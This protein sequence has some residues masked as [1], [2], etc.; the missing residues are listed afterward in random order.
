MT[1]PI[2]ILG[3]DPGLRRTGWGVVEIDGNRLAFVGCGSVTSNDRDGLGDAAAR[4]PRRADA[5][6]RRIPARR[7]RGRGDFRQ[8]GRPGDAQTRPGAR[9]RHG[10][11]GQGRHAGRRI[12]AERGEEEHRRRRP[13]RQGPDAHDDR[14]A[15]AQGRS[16]LA[17]RRRCARHRGDARASPAECGAQG[18]GGAEG[19]GANRLLPD[20]RQAQR[21]HRLLRRGLRHPRRRRRRLSGALLGAHLAGI[22]ARRRS[23]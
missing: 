13:R 10:G 9:H 21:H 11:A 1:R 8:Q 16:G 2:R 20:D 5:R 14:R 22:A 17:R 15:A 6:P 3:I 7:G 12:R 4:H 18:G 19:C 23:R